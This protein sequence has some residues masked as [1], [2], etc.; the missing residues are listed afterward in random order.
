MSINFEAPPD[1]PTSEMTELFAP[2]AVTPDDSLPAANISQADL[3]RLF[4]AGA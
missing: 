2:V 1:A 3:D 4:G